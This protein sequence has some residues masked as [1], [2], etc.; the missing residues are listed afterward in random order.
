MTKFHAKCEIFKFCVESGN[1]RIAQNT[2][3]R[4]P[5]KQ[6]LDNMDLLQF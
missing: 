4:L 5:M 1:T 2:E 6:Q 3:L